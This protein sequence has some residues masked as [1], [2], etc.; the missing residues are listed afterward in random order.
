M[1]LDGKNLGGPLFWTR[2]TSS[3]LSSAPPDLDCVVLHYQRKPHTMNYW[4]RR[5]YKNHRTTNKPHTPTCMLQA[6]QLHI[7]NKR[8]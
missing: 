3:W 2:I 4:K 8:H 6:C 5:R 7:L 1:L